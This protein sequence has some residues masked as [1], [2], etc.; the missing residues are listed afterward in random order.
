MSPLNGKVVLVT[1][2]ASGIGA[3]TLVKLRELGATVSGGD[4]CLAPLG[5]E[6]RFQGV[7]METVD[8]RDPEQVQ[9]FVDIVVERH[10]RLDAVVNSAGVGAPSDLALMTHETSHRDWDLQIGVNLTGTYAVS[11]AALPSLLVQGGAIVNISSIMGLVGSAGFSAYTASKAGVLGL[12]RSMALEYATSGVRV[13][14]VCPGFVNTPM[15]HRFLG[16]SDDPAAARRSLE[17]VTPMGRL[18]EPAEIADVVAWLISD[19][20]SYV[21]G[22]AIPV[23]GGYTAF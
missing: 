2:A 3:A 6:S 19:A 23:D 15:V 11:R 16:R 4:L 20:A 22:A 7:R 17:L 13:N 9:A 10:G 8:V 5:T 21:T 18:A 1:G 12:T 14:A